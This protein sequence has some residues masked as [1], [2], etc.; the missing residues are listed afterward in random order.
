MSDI[1]KFLALQRVKPFDRFSDFPRIGNDKSIYIDRG[2]S[3]QYIWNGNAYV[4]ISSSGSQSLNFLGTYNALANTPNISSG[5]G[6]VGDF[7]V[8][9]VANSNISPPID[10]ITNLQ[11]DDQILAQPSGMDSIWVRVPALSTA[12]PPVSINSSQVL[13]MVALTY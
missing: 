9:S 2:N 13:P 5:S 10:G 4:Q 3:I 1:G 7:Y 12:L 11:L 6:T 8:V